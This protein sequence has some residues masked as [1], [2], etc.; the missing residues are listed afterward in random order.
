MIHALVLI[1]VPPQCLSEQL[2]G[3][4]TCAIVGKVHVDITRTVRFSDSLKR[5]SLVIMSERTIVELIDMLETQVNRLACAYEINHARFG[6]KISPG[7][8]VPQVHNSSF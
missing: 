8:S 7:K 2:Y 1:I 6:S 3:Q 5:L 4:V